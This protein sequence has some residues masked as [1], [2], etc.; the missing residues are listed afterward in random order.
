MKKSAT[1][2]SSDKKPIA[3]D[4]IRST[5][6]SLIFAI[7][8]VLVLALIVKFTGWNESIVG[9]VNQAI[10]I[11]CILGGAFL[12]IKNSEKGALKG[13]IQGLLFSLISMFLFATVQGED[14]FT[15]S[16][17]VDVVAGTI[18]GVISGIIVVNVKR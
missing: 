4:V 14:I 16:T 12:G 13:G 5:L 10:K 1:A 2:Y 18:I 8:L 6:F 7:I 3:G 9:P 17:L 15:L 11:L